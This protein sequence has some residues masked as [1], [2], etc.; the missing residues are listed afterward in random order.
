MTEPASARIEVRG[1]VQ[2]VGFR[3]FVHRLATTLGIDGD[4]RNVNGH[5]VIRAR[6]SGGALADLV[7]GLR[8]RAPVNAEVTAVSLAELPAGVRLEPG[9]T[10]A[11]SVGPDD[12]AS[13]GVAGGVPTDLATCDSC[14]DEVFDPAGRRHRYAFTTCMDCGPRATVVAGLPYDR[15]RTSMRRFP[16]CA[17]CRRE[18]LDPADRRFHAETIAC[19]ACGPRLAWHPAGCTDVTARDDDALRQCEAVIAG[20]GLV[21]VKGV[22][23]YQLVCDAACPDAVRRLRLVKARPRKPFAVMVADTTAA[24]ALVL[25]S[26]VAEPVLR[27]PARPV[28]LLPVTPRGRALAAEV[29]PGLGELGVFLPTSPLHELL[30]ADLA[31]PLV[32]TSGNLAG[33]PIVIDDDA[34]LAGLGPLVDG[35]LAHDRPILARNDDSV[36]RVTGGVAGRSPAT[37][38]RARGLA[39]AAL[40]LPV[41]SPEPVLAV[42][43]QLKHTSALAI[44]DHAVVGPHTGDLADGET[45]QAFL[46]G[47]AH[48]QRL[49]GAVGDGARFVA[50]DLHPDYLSTAYARRRP[51]ERRIAVQHHHAHVVATAAEHGIRGPFL[52]VAYD[53]LGLG[54][55]GTLWGGEVLLATWTGYRRL[56]RFGLAPLPGGEAAVRRP[57][58]M[59]LGYLFGAETAG[60]PVALPP[61]AV[62]AFVARLPER[63]VAVIRRMVARGV[64]CPRAS[65]AGRLFDAVASLLGIRDDASYEGEAA[66][67]LESAARPFAAA[68]SSVAPLPWRVDR[69]DGLLVYDPVPTL[70]AV[71]EPAGSTP[72]VPV[73]MVAARFHATVA[74]VT[75]EIVTECAAVTG[76]RQVCLGGGVFQN[77]LLTG[78]TLRALAGAGLEAHVGRD[79]PVNDGGISY[80]QAAVAA[81]R[82][83]G[84]N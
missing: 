18:Y 2:G 60:D 22:G 77:A 83:A 8:E 29:A 23:G 26:A 63:E 65:S 31:R 67:L 20:G 33:A 21:A 17:D 10:V 36:V 49:H 13:V 15:E 11:A 32:V 66:V 7:R 82:L 74:E 47:V 4:V 3:P 75:A 39:P 38:R 9:F 62:D 61:E 56:A 71:L 40:P 58:R 52:G 46:D 78:A 64:G 80:G 25:V 69:R 79:V 45:H 14:R 41:A 50:H 44:G 68:R 16:L 6:G 54:D 34:A 37:I 12:G 28:A 42:G 84:G 35:V 59:A 27:G 51:P 1:T 5:V 72:A 48:L 57:A 19:P 55:D 73:G 70:A 30:L 24:R 76:V 81:A 53:G 43:A